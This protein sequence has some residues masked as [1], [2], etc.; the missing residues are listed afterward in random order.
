VKDKKAAP[1]SAYDVG[2]AKPPKHSMFKPGTSGNPSGRPKGKH[3]NLQSVVQ[4]VFD[5]K[6]PLV[7]NG[8]SKQ[9]ELIQAM[10]TRIVAMAL[11]GNPAFMKMALELYGSAHAANDNPSPSTGSSFELTAEE[12]EAISKSNLLKNLK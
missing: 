9:V 12:L 2:Y 6:V 8:K 11:S 7:V 4:N 3:K 5:R 10:M 1:K